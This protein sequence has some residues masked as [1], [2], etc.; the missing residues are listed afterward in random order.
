MLQETWETVG[1]AETGKAAMVSLHP[2][3]RLAKADEQAR[4]ALFLVSEDASYVTG[5]LLMVDGGYSAR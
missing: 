3:G 2:I 4:A 1:D 5:H